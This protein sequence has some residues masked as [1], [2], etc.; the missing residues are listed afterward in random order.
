MKGDEEAVARKRIRPK[1]KH[2]SGVGGVGWPDD[3]RKSA[4][5]DPEQQENPIDL[6]ILLRRRRPP[7]ARRLRQPVLDSK[8]PDQPVPTSNPDQTLPS[9]LVKEQTVGQDPERFKTSRRS[10]TVRRMG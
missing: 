9:L 4:C 7:P 8:S 10:E 2:I 5:V 1:M 6:S 3:R